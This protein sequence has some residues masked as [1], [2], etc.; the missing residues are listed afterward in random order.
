MAASPATCYYCKR[1]LPHERH[2]TQLEYLKLFGESDVNSFR[3]LDK[4]SGYRVAETAAKERV[5][6]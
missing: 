6:S 4:S 5:A 3:I 1:N 2:V